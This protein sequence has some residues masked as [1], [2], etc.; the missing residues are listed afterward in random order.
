VR[1]VD[2]AGTVLSDPASSPEF[3]TDRDPA[4]VITSVVP[5]EDG[6]ILMTWQP[7]KYTDPNPGDPLDDPPGTPFRYLPVASIIDFNDY[8]NLAEP[9]TA[10]SFVVPARPSPV[11]VGLRNA[12]NGWY[13]Y[14]GT[15]AAVDGNRLTAKVPSKAT[16]GGKLTVTGKAVKLTRICDPGPCWL[17][18]EP[19][20]GREL[21]LQTRASASAPWRTL[22]T[23]K[24]AKDGTYTIKVTF[25]GTADYRVVAPAIALVP[26]RNAQ[27]FAATTATTVV[28][29]STG[30]GSGSGGQ[31][32][33]GGL[34]ITGA[35][36]ASIAAVGGLLVL[37]GG[38]LTM[39]GRRRAG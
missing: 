20:R 36:V 19:D 11:N 34:P 24:A 12:P 9:T 21:R 14:N 10:T 25:T 39:A 4:A 17:G 13:G 18:E 32:G 8:E 5:R 3:D 1:V 33:G 31:G 23:T 26:G 15:A 6:S 35:P 2:A 16:A 28:R 22:A 7:G 27:S 38:L 37:L 29:G 30:S